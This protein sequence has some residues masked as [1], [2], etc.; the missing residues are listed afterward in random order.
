MTGYYGNDKVLARGKTVSMGL[1][2]QKENWHVTVLV[3]GE[4]LFHGRIPGEYV[5]LRKLLDRL[6]DC[7]IRVASEAGPCGFGLH[8]RLQG[9]GI[10]VLVV[11]PSLIPVESGNKVKT[12]RRDSRKLG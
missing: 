12:D 11:P 3:A 9:D 7:Q 10:E 6:L 5:A 8:D 1:D 2:V 4:E